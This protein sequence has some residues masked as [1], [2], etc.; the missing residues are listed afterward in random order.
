[1]MIWIKKFYLRTLI[2]GLLSLLS[3]PL[4]FAKS[5]SPSNTDPQLDK[6][7]EI[8]EQRS[9]SEDLQ[10]VRL[11]H[12]Q[13]GFWGGQRSQ[14]KNI[15]FYFAGER[16]L[17][18]GKEELRSMITVLH[19]V[20]SQK[21]FPPEP[22]NPFCRFPAR[23]DW[24]KKK[25]PEVLGLWKFPRCPRFETYREALRGES[26]S[27]VF[28]S[29]FLN[30]PS[31]AFGH[32]LLRINKKAAEDGQRYE[33][34][35]YGIN[36]AANQDTNNPFVYAFKGLFG[37]FR[38]SFTSVPY[39]YKVREYNNAESRD[40]WEYELNFTPTDVD[41]LIA[42]LWELGPTTI[43]Y[44]YL[45]EN[46]SYY[47]MT[48]LD[49]IRPDLNLTERLKKFVIP[50]D[51]IH[52]AHSTPGLVKRFSYRPSIRTELQGRLKEMSE[53][54]KKATQK[55]LKTR[56]IQFANQSEESKRKILDAALDSMDYQ[57]SREVQIQDSP[58]SLFK[59][60]ILV[61]RSKIMIT[62]PPLRLT[63]PETE[64]PHLAH[65]S[66]RLKIG[67]AFSNQNGNYLGLNFRFALHDQL[68]P[69][70]GY[71]EY[72]QITFGE[73]DLEYSQKK[74]TT[75]IE[76]F[77][78]V[79]VIS[80]TAWDSFDPH[81]SWKLRVGTERLRSENLPYCQAGVTSFGAGLSSHLGHESFL[82]TAGVRVSGFYTPYCDEKSF[83]GAG[84]DL[85]LRWRLSPNWI[86]LGEA[87]WRYDLDQTVKWYREAS[88][89][90][91]YSWSKHQGLRGFLRERGFEQ[92]VGVEWLIYH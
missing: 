21:D 48:V 4:S 56:K 16:G 19:Q 22:E 37:G 26:V 28:S 65:P 42:H 53:D 66:T 80:T 10:F 35:D 34:L 58:E 36:F 59:N 73:L 55:I 72:A 3:I 78:L 31:S 15:D 68:D 57:Y 71:P 88:L 27:L 23:V 90:M 45:S 50:S 51:T 67:P 38:G 84:P 40:L 82:A 1:M 91:Q 25:L 33:L 44:Y 7:L 24:L 8:A 47:V 70:T 5:S 61:A 46:C 12:Y 81:F 79:E 39:Y 17:K 85:R 60:Q 92:S 29:Y 43:Y 87:H 77:T 74:G 20:A 14:I 75:E 62:T 32:T 49:A 54:E 69:I 30:N 9:L 89:G 11:L 63:P 86:T 13:S 2:L 64:Y 83:L 18:S 6:L 52:L 76:K 41:L